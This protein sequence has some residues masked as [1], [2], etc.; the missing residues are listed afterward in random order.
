MLGWIL[1]RK[2]YQRRGDQKGR[3]KCR[4]VHP[5]AEM[6]ALREGVVIGTCVLLGFRVP[7]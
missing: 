4:R 3:V 5:A 6:S 7:H 1:I 2:G